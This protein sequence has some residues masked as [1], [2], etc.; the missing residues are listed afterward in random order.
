M[1]RAT[2]DGSRAFSGF[3][4]A[5][6]AGVIGSVLVA[7][8]LPQPLLAFVSNTVTNIIGTFYQGY[9]DSL[10]AA[11]NSR[12]TDGL[13]FQIFMFI[14]FALPTF[15]IIQ[16]MS[17]VPSTDD[18]LQ[19]IEAETKSLRQRIDAETESVQEIRQNQ[20]ET[21]SSLRRIEDETESV[22]QLRQIRHD[23][24][25][26]RRQIQAAKERIRQNHGGFSRWLR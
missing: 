21:E 16:T 19:R 18:R 20:G 1:K 6:L 10:Y 23:A 24:E 8:F 15:I 7:V 17:I 22:R 9:I 2:N 12:P 5:I 13:I 4:M 25:S 14:F 3:G 26:F 11:A